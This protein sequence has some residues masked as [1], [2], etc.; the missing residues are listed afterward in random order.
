MLCKSTTPPAVQAGQIL[1]AWHG[2]DESVLRRQLHEVL[3]LSAEQDENAELL[4]T[5]AERLNAY[6]SLNNAGQ[7]PMVR[8]CANLLNHLA[9]QSAGRPLPPG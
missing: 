6:P 1:Q 8:L 3:D 2:G 7:D 5:V 4:H 9:G